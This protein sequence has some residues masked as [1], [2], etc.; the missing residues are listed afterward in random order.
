MPETAPAPKP[1]SEPMCAH[2]KRIYLSGDIKCPQC[3]RKPADV[4]ECWDCSVRFC[5]D[6]KDRV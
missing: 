3:E 4:S 6:C 2:K 5:K 1:A